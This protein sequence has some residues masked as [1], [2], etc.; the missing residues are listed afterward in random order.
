[1]GSKTGAEKGY[2]VDAL[3][4]MFGVNRRTLVARLEGATPVQSG[5]R[6]KLY[7]LSD[8]IQGFISQP[9]QGAE[10]VGLAEVRGRKLAAETELAELKLQRERGELVQSADVRDDL[11]EVIRSLH[12]RLAVT[13]PEQLAPRLAAKTAK[14]A[15][16]ILRAEVGRVFTELRSEHARY[17]AERDAVEGRTD[18]DEGTG[19]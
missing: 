6:Q 3:T 15:A 5:P 18:G 11:V 7:R 10:V 13:M 14:Q 1:M 16:E 2:S 9:L 19:A 12:T 4:R 17:L 8:A